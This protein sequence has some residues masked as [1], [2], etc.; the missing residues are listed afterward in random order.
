MG[1]PFKMK[2]QGSPFNMFGGAKSSP[3]KFGFWRKMKDMFSK[4]NAGGNDLSE[5]EDNMGEGI[6]G[7]EEDGGEGT[8]PQH[9][10]E[11]HGRGGGG[12]GMRGFGGGGG[13]LSGLMGGGGGG[14]GSNSWWQ[15]SRG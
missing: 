8:V 5:A 10:P 15:R 2:H 13:F 12:S 7:L 4:G 1:T 3:A 11:S 14:R 9:G 6:E